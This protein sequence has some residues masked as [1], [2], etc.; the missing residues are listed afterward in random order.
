MQLDEKR[1]I[2]GKGEAGIWRKAGNFGGSVWG[3]GEWKSLPLLEIRNRNRFECQD[4]PKWPQCSGWCIAVWTGHWSTWHG[5]IARPILLLRFGL[6]ILACLP[7]CAT[8]LPM[9]GRVKYF[10]QMNNS[11]G[12]GDGLSPSL[13]RGAGCF[14]VEGTRCS[15]PIETLVAIVRDFPLDRVF[16]ILKFFGFL[17]FKRGFFSPSLFF[18]V[19]EKVRT[20]GIFDWKIEM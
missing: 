2:E 18:L 8:P 13:D 15:R 1:R 17:S 16:E 10:R 9:H 5:Y 20:V 14:Q 4:N 7:R 19:E 12:E 11:V 3:G 6:H